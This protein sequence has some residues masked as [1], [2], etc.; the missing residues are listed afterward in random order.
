MSEGGKGME[1]RTLGRTGLKVSVLGLGGG[2]HS[3]L[4][5]K[6]NTSENASAD[7]VVKAVEWGVNLID[8]AEAYGTE[9]T[10]GLALQKL[11]RENIYV[12]TKFSLYHDGKLKTPGDLEKSVDGSLAQLNT[13]YIDI[14]HLHAV[15]ESDYTYA[16]EQLVPEMLKMREKGKI[17][18]LGITE[19]FPNDPSH[20]MLQR[21]VK[22]DC[23]DVMM[24]G[25]NLLN[26]S[27]RDKVFSVTRKNN[28]GVLDMFAVRRVLAN[29]QAL[30][31]L[32]ADLLRQGLVDETLI[33][34]S[35]PLAFLMHSEEGAVSMTDAAYRYCVHEPGIHSV[36]SG[37]GNIQHL[38]ENIES[39]KRVALPTRDFDKINKIFALVDHISGN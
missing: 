6:A 12:S 9:K 31:D 34:K 13:E 37:T 15:K 36:L 14:Y 21:A 35:D 22:D 28:I 24:V 38:Q 20:K 32:V 25:F 7:L 8:T 2:G 26:Q 3:K 17:R 18:F 23:W 4:G 27:A 10:I 19:T 16:V 39:V 1:Y 33:D 30:V 5:I 29:P 11:K